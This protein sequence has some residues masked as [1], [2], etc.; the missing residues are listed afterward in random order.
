MTLPCD[1]FADLAVLHFACA[2]EREYA[3]DWWRKAERTPKQTTMLNMD[4]P[5]KDQLT[6]PV[7]PKKYRDVAKAVEEAP[8]WASKMMGVMIAGIGMLCFMA[9]ER[10]GGG[11][12]LSCTCLFLTLLYM[13]ANRHDIGSEFRLLLD[14]TASENKCNE[15]I[16]FI[17]WL[18]AIGVAGSRGATWP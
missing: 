1:H 8:A 15:V 18:V 10:L 11:P 6:I 3:D 7:Q 9:H 13:D 12:N 4:A 5:T 17:F 14:N 16:F 2:G